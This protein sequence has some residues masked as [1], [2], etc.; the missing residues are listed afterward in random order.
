VVISAP[1]CIGSG[2]IKCLP[3]RAN[4]ASEAAEEHRRRQVDSL[5]WQ[6]FAAS[7]G[8]ARAQKCENGVRK[9]NR[10]QVLDRKSTVA[11]QERAVEWAV[12]LLAMA[13]KVKDV[14]ALALES[15]L[16]HL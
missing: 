16:E 6:V 9:A 15:F 8:L 2:R 12:R 7:R 4:D 10:H 14:C 3:H 13:R 5:V 1:A 11:Q